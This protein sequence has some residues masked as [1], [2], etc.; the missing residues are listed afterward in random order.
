MNEDT[1]IIIANNIVDCNTRSKTL[2][3]EHDDNDKHNDDIGK[4]EKAELAE[5][6]LFKELNG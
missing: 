1:F 2:P 5:L 6:L 3:L 4:K